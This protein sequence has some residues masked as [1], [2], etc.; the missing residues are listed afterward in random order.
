MKAWVVISLGLWILCGGPPSWAVGPSTGPGSTLSWTANT[1]PDL[2]G[3]RIY[4]NNSPGGQTIPGP[5]NATILAPT[6]THTLGAISD[7][8]YYAKITAYDQS[9]NESAASSE[10]SFVFN[11]LFPPT[12]GIFP[13]LLN[14]LTPLAPL[15]PIRFNIPAETWRLMLTKHK[16]P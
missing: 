16:S 4:Y 8:Q 10:V 13:E 7:G 1:E 15:N 6:T 5:P 11:G 2:A 3:Y 9:G 14:P 12:L